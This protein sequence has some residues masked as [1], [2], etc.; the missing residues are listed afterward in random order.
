MWAK[1]QHKAQSLYFE[2]IERVVADH[3][4]KKPIIEPI[5]DARSWPLIEMAGRCARAQSSCSS[6]VEEDNRF[7]GISSIVM[8]SWPVLMRS[9][10]D[11]TVSAEKRA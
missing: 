6:L 11:L 4:V 3:A 5:E 7:P 8:A 10:T 1:D 2:Q 9:R